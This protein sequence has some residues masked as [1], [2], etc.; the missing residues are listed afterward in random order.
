[1][2]D[3]IRAEMHASGVDVGALEGQLDDDGEAADEAVEAPAE[4]GV[5][6]PEETAGEEQTPAAP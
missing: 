5:S 1:V 2:L 4:A 3:G 6:A